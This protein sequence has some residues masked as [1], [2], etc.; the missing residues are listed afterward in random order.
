M[1]ER[2]F[3]VSKKKYKKRKFKKIII[4]GLIATILIISLIIFIKK[5]NNNNLA[6]QWHIII[7]NDYINVREGNT[8]KNEDDDKRWTKNLGRVTKGEKYRILELDTTTSN[9]YVW[10]KINYKKMLGW[11][12]SDRY[13]PFVEEVNNPKLKA[14]KDYII[15]YAPPIIK[16]FDEVLHVTDIDNIT[17]SKVEVI[18]SSK[19]DLT[20]KIY[21]EKKPR[22]GDGPQYWIKYTAIDANGLT[23]SKRQKI[24]FDNPPTNDQ[25]LDF[26]NIY[27]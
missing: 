7:K 16:F 10:Y 12:A 27:D 15:D 23:S 5:R 2:G 14:N 22:E 25:V 9:K 13:N 19:Y 24:T 20:Y 17:L 3:I 18:E 11:I 21:I 26:S 8:E 4:I 6:D 1:I